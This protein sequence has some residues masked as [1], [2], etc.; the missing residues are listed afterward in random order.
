M[1]H[2]V[3]VYMYML[4]L[5]HQVDS[6]VEKLSLMGYEQQMQMAQYLFQLGNYR[7]NFRTADQ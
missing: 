7:P 5:L 1:S 4:T 2:Y 3:Y 6:D